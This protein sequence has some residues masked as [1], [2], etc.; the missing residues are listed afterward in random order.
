MNAA[1]PGDRLSDSTVEQKLLCPASLRAFMT[2]PTPPTP[3]SR[4]LLLAG[5]IVVVAALYFAQQVLIPIAL[6]LLISFLLTPLVMV[7]ER[8]GLPRIPAA[9]TVVVLACGVIGG[10]GWMM[11]RQ[12]TDLA[13]KLPTYRDNIEHKI[14]LIHGSTRGVLSNAAQT[15]QS[16]N[17]E[18]ASTRPT[19]QPTTTAAA[20]TA[21]PADPTAATGS[22]AQRD[23]APHSGTRD[24]PM[25]V[26][27][28]EP[29]PTASTLVLQTFGPLFD[30][31]AKAFVVIVLVI[32]ILLR[33][34][35]LRDRIICLIG[36]GR[37]SLTT[38]AMDDAAGR[39][40]RY[41][42]MQTIINGTYGLGAGI[43]LYFI[44]V[45]N[46]ALWGLLAAALRFI[47]YL[48]PWLGA[49]LP[50][51]ISLAAFD[52]WTPPILTMGM[53]I[54]LEFTTNMILEPWLYGASTGV[55]P[56]AVLV[57]AVFWAWLWGG[58]GLL[59]ATPLTVCLV[60]LGKYVPQLEFLNILL[61]D[62]PVFDPKTRYY[63]RLSA[64]DVEEAQEVA[65]EILE[66]QSPLQL[67]D[68]VLLPAL[69]MAQSDYRQ[70]TL[71]DQR[72]ALLRRSVREQLD[73]LE[74]A[75]EEP[76]PQQQQQSS[77]AERRKGITIFCLPARDESD[78]LTGLALGQLLRQ[79][80]YTV[81][82][83]AHTAL[84]GEMVQEVL[85]SKADIVCIC[86][87][88]PVAMSHA[89]Y[90]YKRLKAQSPQLK[91]LVG[92]WTSKKDPAKSATLMRLTDTQVVTH[93][94]GALQ[95]IHQLAQP[96]LLRET[97]PAEITPQPSAGAGTE[98]FGAL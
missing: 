91:I 54:V 68:Q 4:I 65:E 80:G 19:S 11:T 22:P 20:Q 30:P 82:V 26:E 49:S 9:M 23:A 53:F 1:A 7:L 42:L 60:V 27:T 12:V 70:G 40:S 14:S 90:L 98:P 92:L 57:A 50:I 37:V 36:Q 75:V 51:F 5:T 96:L 79:N 61:G 88:P 33:R 46:A 48:G 74:E 77:A 6:A 31:L 86:A 32:F 89:R 28:V 55:S 95:H 78:E 72:M 64:G 21:D 83:P 38:K 43:G 34:E 97:H 81:Q 16:I 94:E 25:M 52:T 76:T 59:L 41:L 17:R 35:D 29:P 3:G 66:T 67:Y 87:L 44:G 84:A 58:I 93:F 56:L 45:P 69:G 71:D 10:M 2:Q 18:L 73:E 85:Q 8:W 13:A 15:L 62:E 47:P 24:N 63:Q 39:V